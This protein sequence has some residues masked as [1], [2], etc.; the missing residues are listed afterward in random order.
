M[1]RILNIAHRGFTK[2]F[3]D[4]TLEAFEAAIGIPVD[5][6]ECDVHETADNRFIIFHDREI[7]AATS[8]R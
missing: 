7:L 4:N 1:K 3:P 6:I 5:G 8:A 2:Q